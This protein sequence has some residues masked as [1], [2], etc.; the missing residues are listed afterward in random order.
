MSCFLKTALSLSGRC[1]GECILPTSNFDVALIMG[2]FHNKSASY[3]L[4]FLVDLFESVG[5]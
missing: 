5:N 1:K 2:Y 4:Q 3:S